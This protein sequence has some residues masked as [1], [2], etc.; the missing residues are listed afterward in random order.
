MP[1][2]AGL[3]WRRVPISAK[4]THRWDL[5]RRDACPSEGACASTAVA[6]PL[7]QRMK[8]SISL[9]RTPACLAPLPSTEVFGL[10]SLSDFVPTFCACSSLVWRQC[11][12]I[13][14][15]LPKR[16]DIP[17]KWQEMKIRHTARTP[18]R[19]LFSTWLRRT[20]RAH[21][22]MLLIMKNT[23]VN[24]PLFSSTF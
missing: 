22:G 1:N 3:R 10:S 2:A 13:Y 23:T 19:G 4:T 17:A 14:G 24:P 7:V 15:A 16:T 12:N 5:W 21:A 18:A 9:L 6:S 8:R 20:S 11:I